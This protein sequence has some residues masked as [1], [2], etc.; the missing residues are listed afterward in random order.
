MDSEYV[1]VFTEASLTF[2]FLV[3]ETFAK[4][5]DLAKRV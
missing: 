3:G 4:H 2:P 1:K 5:F